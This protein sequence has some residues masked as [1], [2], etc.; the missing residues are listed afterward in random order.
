MK[1]ELKGNV[2]YKMKFMWINDT[3]LSLP[4]NKK[5]NMISQVNYANFSSLFM[6]CDA[7][8]DKLI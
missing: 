1:N 7:V 5:L 8:L 3:R 2:S 4:K 6:T